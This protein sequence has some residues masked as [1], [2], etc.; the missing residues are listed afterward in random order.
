[1]ALFIETLEALIKQ[2]YESPQEGSYTSKL[3]SDGTDRILKKVG[4]EASEVIIAAK[5]NDSDELKQEAADLIYHLLVS[6]R[7]KGVSSVCLHTVQLF[8]AIDGAILCATIFKGWLNGVIAEIAVN[9]SR[10]VNIFLAFP[11]GVKSHE[12]IS[13]SSYIHS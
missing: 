4:E 8:V 13:P 12:K 10:I 11:C 5:N 7:D 9:G 6:L 3:F 2:R 1:M